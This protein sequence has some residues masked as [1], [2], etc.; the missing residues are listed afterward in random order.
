MSKNFL[1]NLNLAILLR[2]S[3][4][5]NHSIWLPF[6]LSLSMST[7][8]LLLSIPY[9]IVCSYYFRLKNTKLLSFFCKTKKKKLANNLAFFFFL[10]KMKSNILLNKFWYRFKIKSIFRCF[11]FDLLPYKIILCLLLFLLTTMA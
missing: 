7:S 2:K 3:K 10:K 1:K 8:L 9:K 6:S 11:L 5:R 4:N